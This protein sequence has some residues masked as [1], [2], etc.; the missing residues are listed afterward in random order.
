VSTVVAYYPSTNFV[1]NAGLL[2]KRFQVP[3]LV[4]AGG[5][6]TYRNCCL[7]E[8]MRAMETAAKELGARFELVV[9]PD[10]QHG[11][12]IDGRG[13]RRDY[14]LDAWRR[15]AEVLQAQHPLKAP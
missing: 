6:D 7:I 13:Y 2:V 4:L 8:S 10:G 14:E 12:N 9:Y 11:F 1:P 15:T 3:V 5:Q